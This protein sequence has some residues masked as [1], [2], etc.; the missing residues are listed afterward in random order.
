MTCSLRCVDP[1][2]VKGFA[3]RHDQ[4]MLECLRSILHVNL[5][6]GG[7]ET[8]DIVPLPISLGGLGV[9]GAQGST[10]GHL[11]GLLA[12]DPGASPRCRSLLGGTVGA[13]DLTGPE[14]FEFGCTRD[15]WQHEA[16]FRIQETFTAESLFPGWMTRRC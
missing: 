6:D 16:A 12:H 3:R 7:A 15:G 5:V 2:A 11:G 4:G 9:C 10:L 13:H 8:R 1:E 14:H